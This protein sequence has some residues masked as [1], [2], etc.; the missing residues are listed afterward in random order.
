MAFLKG[1]PVNQSET[2]VFNHWGIIIHLL[3]AGFPYDVIEGM[4]EANI[5]VVL[6]MITAFEAREA[7]QEARMQRM[8]R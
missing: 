1:V 8:A 4:T 5:A 7:E 3:K 6:G 2:M